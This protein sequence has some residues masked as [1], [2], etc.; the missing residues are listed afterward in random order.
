MI[1]TLGRLFFAPFIGRSTLIQ[2][3]ELENVL[4]S[5]LLGPAKP[6]LIRR[7]S[8]WGIRGADCHD[9][10]QEAVIVAWQSVRAGKY[11]P[12]QGSL[13]GWF[14]GILKHRAVDWIRKETSKAR[15]ATT[16]IE[17]PQEE[18]TQEVEATLKEVLRGVSASRREIVKLHMAGLTTSEIAKRLSRSPG[19]TGALLAAG[20][21]QLRL[22]LTESGFRPRAAV[23]YRNRLAR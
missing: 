10:Y 3:P 23:N 17:E 13:D 15:L 21:R 8:C 22:Q 12:E 9:V 18:P 19:R 2:D 20:R 16:S 5:W 14:R 6:R 1:R 7:L 11:H 4:R